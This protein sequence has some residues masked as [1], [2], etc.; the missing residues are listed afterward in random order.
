MNITDKIKHLKFDS[1]RTTVVVRNIFGASIIKA[2]SIL[3]SLVLIP[4]TIGY[5]S[6]ELYGIWLALSTVIMWMSLFDLGFGNGLRNK[7]AECI[8]KGNIVK[9]REYI[10]TAYVYFSFV[11]VPISTIAFFICPFINWTSLLS[12]NQNYQEELV[13]VMKII[14]VFFA[15]NS[16]AK[17]QNIVLMAL[18][19][20][21]IASLLD[22]LGL[23]LSLITILI[24]KHNTTG[25]LR[26]LAY[27]MTVSPFVVNMLGFVWLYGYKHKELRPLVTLANRLLVSD[28]LGLSIKFFIINVSTVV[29]Y[30][31]INVLIS[32]VSGPESVTEYNIVYKYLSIPLILSSIITTPYWSAYTEAYTIN[33]YNWMRI[34]YIRLNKVCYYLFICLLVLVLIHPFVFNLWL[35]NLLEIHFNMILIVSIYV[36]IMIYN[37]INANIVNG[38]GKLKISLIIA[39]L[40]VIFNI[41]LALF[42]GNFWGAIGVI[43]SVGLLTLIPAIILR[44][45]IIKI[46]NKTASGIWKQ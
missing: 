26:L 18:Q 30:Y 37:Q 27:A 12:V 10:S 45:Q 28:I 40:S 25:S 3:I 31:T 7:T 33:D 13:S 5:V 38:I 2:C 41:P 9:A 19:R 1:P 8:A 34:S 4:V 16:V 42:L 14:T 29:L 23:L 44:M 15:L 20:N 11:F 36:M 6:S 17:L 21:A 46:L 22:M 24:L 35:G 39:F 32:R 43:A